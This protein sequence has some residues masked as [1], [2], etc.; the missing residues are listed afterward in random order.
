M[1]NLVIL[2]DSNV[3]CLGRAL[4]STSCEDLLGK[5]YIDYVFNGSL[6]LDFVITLPG[7]REIINPMVLKSLVNA[8]LCHPYAG[9]PNPFKGCLVLMFG[10]TL[11]NSLGL[12]PG[13]RDITFHDVDADGMYFLPKGILLDAALEVCEKFERG[14]TILREYWPEAEIVIYGG[15][16]PPRD[17]AKTRATMKLLDV[18]DPKLRLEVY[19]QN[20][21]ALRIISVRT[22]TSFAL[23]PAAV[24]EDDGFIAEKYNDDGFHGTSLYGEVIIREIERIYLQHYYRLVD[25]SYD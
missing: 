22:S 12:E 5:V 24:L 23:P 16:P 1:Q 15:P 11:V 9:S 2:G 18:P 4:N 19:R 10:S 13:L 17:S 3:I 21:E 7:G 8:G 25:R 6:I 14:L 20:A